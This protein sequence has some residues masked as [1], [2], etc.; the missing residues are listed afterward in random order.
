MRNGTAVAACAVALAIAVGTLPVL[1]PSE[2]SA[3]EGTKYRKK[4]YDYRYARK[5]NWRVEREYEARANDLDP[6]GD[7]KGYPNWARAALSPKYD[8]GFR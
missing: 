3:A 2:A 5:R 6:A 8:R 4:K 7:Y 1:V